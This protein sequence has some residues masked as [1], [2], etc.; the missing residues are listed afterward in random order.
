MYQGNTALPQPCRV[1]RVL[2][3]LEPGPAGTQGHCPLSAPVLCPGP[4]GCF[5]TFTTGSTPLCTYSKRGF[6]TKT[7]AREYRDDSDYS[8]EFDLCKHLILFAL[9]LVI[10][11]ESTFHIKQCLSKVDLKSVIITSVS[12]TYLYSAHPF[13]IQKH[14]SY[15]TRHH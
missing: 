14:G 4:R 12:T 15:L 11:S 2:L 9:L 1:C 5:N 7:P 13:K 3:S 6:T 8:V 10:T